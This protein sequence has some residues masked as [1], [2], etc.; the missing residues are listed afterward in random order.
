[1]TSANHRVRLLFAT[2]LGAACSALVALSS[3]ASGLTIDQ[4]LGDYAQRIQ[5]G[6]GTR[7]LLQKCTSRQGPALAEWKGNIECEFLLGDLLGTLDNLTKRHVQENWQAVR[8]A[9]ACPDGPYDATERDKWVQRCLSLRRA[10]L[11]SLGSMEQQLPPEVKTEIVSEII[12]ISKRSGEIAKERRAYEAQLDERIR[13]QRL[14]QALL[15]ERKVELLSKI[16][17]ANLK[18]LGFIS[19]KKQ[20]TPFDIEKLREIYRER[21]TSAHVKQ[22]IETKFPHVL[23]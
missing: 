17:E 5:Q 13:L 8:S 9:L 2:A 19:A 3:H 6:N 16:N 18:I 14:E 12:S 23:P 4:L 22:I 15:D 20:L 7:A 11:Q 1:M 21:Y 10:E